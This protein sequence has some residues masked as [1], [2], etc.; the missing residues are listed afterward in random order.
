MNDKLSNVFIKTVNSH[1]EADLYDQLSA[2]Y[3]QYTYEINLR[4]QL[5]TDPLQTRHSKS[6]QS[7]S[8]SGI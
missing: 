4:I 5:K 6:W 2:F 3:F 1:V 8:M 7:K